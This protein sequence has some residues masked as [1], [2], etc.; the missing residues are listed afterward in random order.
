MGYYRFNIKSEIGDYI[1][2]GSTKV[3]GNVASPLKVN[4]NKVMA[5][6]RKNSRISDINEICFP[7]E[8]MSDIKDKNEIVYI[9]GIVFSKKAKTYYRNGIDGTIDEFSDK[10][11]TDGNII[12]VINFKNYISSKLYCIA[13]A[14][15]EKNSDVAFSIQ[16]F[17]NKHIIYN[18][19]IYSPQYPG[20]IYPHFL[21]KDEIALFQG[22]KPK[23]GATEI[24][25][26]MKAIFGFPDMLFDNCTTY[27]NCTYDDNKLRDVIDPH[28]SNRMS[29]FSFYLKDEKE[30][31]PISAFQPL[32]I[33]KCR[34][35]LKIYT[36]SSGYCIFE[37]T[38]FTNKDRLILKETE[39]FS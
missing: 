14:D 38:I 23:K 35:G 34:E 30:I 32:M 17:S 6:L 13:L 7:L 19:F 29:V 16:L 24:N 3:N 25:F 27:P 12:E 37:T 21:L 2:I 31:T 8:K 4:D 22:M 10:N 11:I 28:H 33:V 18:Q 20:L 39:T 9:N 15:D 36:K 1:T 26:N 5:A